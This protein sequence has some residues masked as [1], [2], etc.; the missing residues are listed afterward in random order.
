MKKNQWLLVVL[1]VVVVVP[2]WVY[3]QNSCQHDEKTFR[4]VKYMRNYDADTITFDI[5]Q[6]H[7]L[8]GKA[9]AIRVN[10][11]DT[12][13]IKTK[14]KCE[15]DAG[16]NAKRL[17]E[18]LLKRAK[19]I[20]LMNV[21]RGKYFRIVADVIIDGQNLTDYLLKNQLAYAYD[22]GTKKKVN[23]CNFRNTAS[24]KVK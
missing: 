17:V 19:R 16:R 8:L 12:P 18:N 7:P 24:E 1:F 3:S 20:D 23:W 22:G 14:N 10:G 15:K 9:I 6:V 4:C 21:K 13:E 2:V 5:P 11:V